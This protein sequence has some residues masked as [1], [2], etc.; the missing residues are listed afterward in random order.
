MTEDGN[1][2][3]PRNKGG[4]PTSAEQR[5]RLLRELQN[6][7]L[8][9]AAQALKLIRSK[10]TRQ[11]VKVQALQTLAS[12]GLKAAEAARAASGQLVRKSPADFLEDLRDRVQALEAHYKRP[13]I[14]LLAD[15]TVDLR[16]VV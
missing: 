2:M 15:E 3:P 11:S 5:V 4:R 14:E 9:V 13:I 16:R 12:V 10:T 8:V 1:R 7:D 6:I